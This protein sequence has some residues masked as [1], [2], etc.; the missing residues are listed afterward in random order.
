[1]PQESTIDRVARTTGVG[2]HKDVQIISD[3]G[4]VDPDDVDIYRGQEAIWFAHNTAWATIDFSSA[5]GSPFYEKTFHVPAGGTV[6]S[7]LVR[8]DAK[9]GRY[10]YTVTGPNGHNDP[11]VIIHN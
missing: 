6:S 11:G 1:M 10:K 5:A 4:K 7:G 3:D 8:D 2:A 9:P